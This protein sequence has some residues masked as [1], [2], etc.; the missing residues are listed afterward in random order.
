[1]PEFI[2]ILVAAVLLMIILLMAF[3]G[4]FISPAPTRGRGPSY[5][6]RTIQLGGNFTVMYV[7]G[8]EDVAS[9]EGEVSKGLFS[10]E[11]KSIGFDV[12]NIGDVSE[13]IIEL[14]ILNSNH[15]GNLMIMVNGLEVYRGA[16]QIGKKLISFDGDILSDTNTI[17]VMAESSGWKIWAPT[18]YI[19]D[20]NVSVN[21]LGKKTQSFIF[22][23]TD[24][25]I[26]YIS[27]AR[28]L[29]F[30]TRDGNGDLIARLNGVDIFSGFTTVYTDFSVDA[31]KI[32]NNI[33][34]L[35]TE[36]NTKY[37][38]TSAQLV[39]FYG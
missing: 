20:A 19:F 18:V 5:A 24:S 1:M 13:G 4:G 29:I 39:L 26:I 7:T 3:G 37:N 35:S 22:N 36:P 15:Y 8:E 31:L 11:D 12:P 9:F 25:E 28:L 27:R 38:I 30:G 32:G 14:K 33:L 2:P 21:Y 16:P 23:L 34:S 10:T 17:N 6:S